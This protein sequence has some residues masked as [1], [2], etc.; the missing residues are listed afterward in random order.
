MAAGRYAAAIEQPP[1]SP[2]NERSWLC[3]NLVKDMTET[4]NEMPCTFGDRDY[5]HVKAINNPRP[6][7]DLKISD[8]DVGL[9]PGYYYRTRTRAEEDVRQFRQL[10]AVGLGQ[11]QG[12]P[13]VLPQAGPTDAQLKEAKADRDEISAL[14]GKLADKPTAVKS[15]GELIYASLPGFCLREQQMIPP[16][17]FDSSQG[18]LNYVGPVYNTVYAGS[19][20]DR[21][22][23]FIN[24]KGRPYWLKPI[25]RWHREQGAGIT[26]SGSGSR[27]GNNVTPVVPTLTRGG[28]V[29]PTSTRGGAVV[30]PPTRGGGVVP[31]PNRGGTVAPSPNR[32]GA[33]TGTGAS[34]GNGTSH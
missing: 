27:T 19:F 17:Y 8:C 5:P 34:G 2:E 21:I 30:P 26:T 24:A 9:L 25:H 15:L 12:Q 3:S 31:T 28:G 32:G 6:R 29:V 4:N 7:K 13:V 23:I 14:G 18:R 22:N 20:G 10:S 16:S 11:F 33:S 1:A